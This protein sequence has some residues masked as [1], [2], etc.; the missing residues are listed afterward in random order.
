MKDQINNAQTMVQ[1][2]KA[3]ASIVITFTDENDFQWAW[4]FNKTDWSIIPTLIGLLHACA[5]SLTQVLLAAGEGAEIDETNFS[6]GPTL[7]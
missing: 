6:K 5:A 7:N 4:S 2:T 3:K 1:L